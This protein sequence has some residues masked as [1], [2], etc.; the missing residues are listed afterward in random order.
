[1]L[2]L[3][4]AERSIFVEFALYSEKFYLPSLLDFNTLRTGHAELRISCRT[5]SDRIRKFAFLNEVALVPLP[6]HKIAYQPCYYYWLLE[7]KNYGILVISNGKIVVPNFVNIGQL[8]Q[9]LKLTAKHR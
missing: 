6:L 8:V 7:I 9:K 1:M 3:Y 2:S 5:V 4:I